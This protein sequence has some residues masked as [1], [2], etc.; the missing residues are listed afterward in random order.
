[1]AAATA[2]PWWERR[3]VAALLALAFA[4]P[5]VWPAIPPLVD[6]PGHIA[7]YHIA[8]DRPPALM[9]VFAYHWRLIGNLGVDLAVIPLAPLLGVERAAKLV[10]LLIPALT[11]GG[12]LA[13][14]RAAHGRVPPTALFA[15]PLALGWPFQFG[16]VNYC[17]GMALAFWLLAAWIALA[18]RPRLR[19]AVALAGSWV[20]WTCHVFAWGL[21]GLMV[22]G[23]ELA[24]Q[25]RRGAAW[26]RVGPQAALHALA[27]AT[28]ALASLV[29][30]T[31]RGD[32][33][34]GF[35]A[36]GKFQLFAAALRDH[37]QLFDQLCVLALFGVL[38]FAFSHPRLRFSAVL[39]IPALAVFAFVLAMP[40]VLFGASYAD[41]R[42]GPYAI[43]L[44]LLAITPC[45]D[46]ALARRLAL[47]GVAFIALRLG[48][49]T[50]SLLSAS[51]EIERE[52][53]VLPAIPRG[54]AVFALVRHGCAPEWDDRRFDH[55]GSI[56]I[57]RRDAIT[58][59]Q[60]TIP[61]QQLLTMRRG[62][63]LPRDR[64]PSQLV[65]VSLCDSMGIALGTTLR[66][67]PVWRYD[68]LWTIG[69]PRGAASDPLFVPVWSSDRS[70]LYRIARPARPAS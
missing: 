17:L 48:A 42:V 56:A 37:W 67:S 4:I 45:A 12:M 63:G 26:W 9:R 57:L 35:T 15:L 32:T 33:W 62:R 21:M 23:A 44:A 13:V 65:H 1:M 43:A 16:F 59:D 24:L 64:D 34:G 52:L 68:Y 55:V 36:A 28:P 50:L 19:A 6:A 18:E 49:A 22:F 30:G 25:R 8:F 11:A 46:R 53:A 7:R 51:R 58:N 38:I 39:A 60:W 10:I 27:L 29:T 14:A 47:A 69:F 3:G 31:A 66:T 61:G 70:A 41:T 40:G 20:I 54:S 2:R 5:L